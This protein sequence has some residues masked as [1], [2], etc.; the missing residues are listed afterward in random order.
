VF[1]AGRRRSLRALLLRRQI[2]VF[3][4]TKPARSRSSFVK[5]AKRP[6]RVPFGC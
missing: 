3:H 1:C 6:R 4:P 2:H 5:A